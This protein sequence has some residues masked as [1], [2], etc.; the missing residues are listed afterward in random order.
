VELSTFSYPDI[1]LVPKSDLDDALVALSSCW[2]T[3]EGCWCEHTPVGKKCANCLARE[4]LKKHGVI[5]AWDNGS[6]T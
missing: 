6:K 2:A 1:P 5:G 3:F 4:V